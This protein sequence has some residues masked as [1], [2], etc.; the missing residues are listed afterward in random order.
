MKFKLTLHSA[1]YKGGFFNARKEF[2]H[3]IR[4]DEGE[5][6][7]TAGTEDTTFFGKVDRNANGNGSARIR[8]LKG[9]RQW[10]QRNYNQG[11]VL[12]I[13]IISPSFLKITTPS[14]IGGSNP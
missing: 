8:N 1:Y 7:V 5:I 13:E 9:F 2:D 4:E 12:E 10:L 14:K 11:D 6:T 3:L